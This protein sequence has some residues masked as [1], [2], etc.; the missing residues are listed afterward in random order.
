MIETVIGYAF[1]IFFLLMFL[2]T[3]AG[4]MFGHANVRRFLFWVRGRSEQTGKPVR[5]FPLF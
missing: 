4:E 2:L 5:R 3:M 1:G